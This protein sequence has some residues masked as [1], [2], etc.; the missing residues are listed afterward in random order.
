[1][2]SYLSEAIKLTEN[3]KTVLSKRYLRRDD[4]GNPIETSEDL[5]WRVSRTIAEADRFD[6]KSP[7]EIDKLSEQF[8]KSMTNLEFM[9]NSPTLMNAGRELGQLSACFVL[10]V[11]DSLDAI[12]ETIKNT[13]LIHKSGGGTGFSFSRLRPKN[14]IVKS[15][16]G[17]SSGP[18]SFIEVFN[19]ATEAVK[20][21]GTRRGANMA[22]LRVDHP[23][24]LDFINSKFEGHR[25][26]NF[27]ISVGI[28]NKFMEAVLKDEDYDL[29]HPNSKQVI[30]R[31]RAKE[32]F[33][34]IVNHAWKNGEPGI[35]FLDNINKDNPTP[36]IG[37]IE[38]TNPCGEVPLLPYEACNLGSLNVGNMIKYNQD[39]QPEVDWDRLE[40]VTKLTTHFLDNV[41]T[42]NNFPLPQIEEMVRNN[43]KIGLGL[44]GWADLLMLLNIPYNSEEGINLAKQIMEFIDYHSKVKSIELA[45]ERGKFAN[46]E[47][48]I[49]DGN[50]ALYNRYRDQSAGK[51]SDDDWYELDLRIQEFGIRNATTT[52]IAPT[53][54]ISMI[55]AAS[56][57]IEPLFGLTFIRKVM[58]GTELIEVNPNF[59]KIAKE[60]D[61]YS[62][63]LMR[64]ISIHGSIH[65]INDVPEDI[66]RVFVTAHDITP[67]WHVKM[68]AAFQIHTDNAVSKTVNF[69]EDATKDE[70]AETYYLAYKSNL[71]GITVYRDKSRSYQPMNIEIKDDKTEEDTVETSTNSTEHCLFTNPDRKIVTPRERPNLTYGM[72]D[73][74]QTGCGPLYI[75]IN[76]DKKGL[77]EVFARMGKSG[78]CATSQAEA[79][80]RMISLAL[81]AGVDIQSIIDQLKGIRCPAP[82]FGKGGVI[83]SCSDAIGKVLE[84]N[85]EKAFNLPVSDNNGKNINSEEQS[86][87]LSGKSSIADIGLCPECPECGQMLEFGEG[88]VI[89]KNCGFSRC[90]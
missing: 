78:G 30:Q 45:K 81:R 90:S 72:T 70:I 31:L 38:S 29:V 44:M 27:N 2:A 37:E 13:A 35:V 42:M 47:G 54:T 58:D 3:A 68:Q 79:T 69:K 34:V 77:C 67:E 15:T 40:Y 18:V 17:V 76:T 20:Q 62:E 66:Q 21:G 43:R 14:D 10:P 74:I 24:I 12:F 36:K 60:K 73:K 88:C 1:M 25:L 46:F 7:E 49:Y 84:R 22:I 63:E 8:Y 41:I 4:D 39:E 55:A 61:F 28:T 19:A 86:A 51:I 59:E 23:D 32:V 57:G 52:C 75:T 85:L 89:C 48:S 82:S 53:G 33:D 6:G 5:F 65:G 71:K 16:M 50:T 64:E 56:G 9:P 11:D 26:N 80:G 83:L 87:N